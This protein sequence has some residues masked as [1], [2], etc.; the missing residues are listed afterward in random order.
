M[1]N[2]IF[3]IPAHWTLTTE[4]IQ[5]YLKDGSTTKPVK[6]KVDISDSGIIDLKSID[7]QGEPRE[8]FDS[9]RTDI[10]E[11]YGIGRGEKS[12]YKD[13]RGLFQNELQ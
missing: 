12:F 11:H 2:P 10:G 5:C 4:T 1:S 7:T 8:N 9:L 6:V 3:D 13:Y